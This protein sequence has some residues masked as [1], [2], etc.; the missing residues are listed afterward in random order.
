MKS[1]NCWELMECPEQFK[2]KCDAFLLDYGKD[3][4]FIMNAMKGGPYMQTR[5]GDCLNCP[6]FK[7]NNPELATFG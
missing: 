5:Q 2:K 4:W 6:W 1:Q 3:C 7:K